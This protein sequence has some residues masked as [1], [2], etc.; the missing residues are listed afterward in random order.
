MRPSKFVK[1]S[2]G[3]V[4]E[5]LERFVRHQYERPFPVPS[6]RLTVPGLSEVDLILCYWNDTVRMLERPGGEQALR[7]H[8]D[9]ILKTNN[10]LQDEW[11]RCI[12]DKEFLEQVLEALWYEADE[13]GRDTLIP[14]DLADRRSL[15][16]GWTWKREGTNS[17]LLEVTE[18]DG[19]WI[20]VRDRQKWRRRIASGEMWSDVIHR[21]EHDM[22]E[23]NSK[24]ESISKRMDTYAFRLRIYEEVISCYDTYDC[25]FYLDCEEISESG[26][27]GH[28]LK[29]LNI[30]DAAIINTALRLYNEDGSI[31]TSQNKL[32]ETVSGTI[33]DYIDSGGK[34]HELLRCNKS[35]GGEWNPHNVRKVLNDLG[36]YVS[37]PG[38]GRGASSSP[39]VLLEEMVARLKQR[40]KE[41]EL[42]FDEGSQSLLI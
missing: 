28:E 30:I 18:P 24:F 1:P 17:F 29:S 39:G 35:E 31:Y 12:V 5:V 21:F 10:H 25:C 42:F 4:D 23:T 19:V 37:K 16:R 32:I 13:F 38:G 22:E 36:I 14:E 20:S 27:L 40:G 33:Q 8:Y 9:E 2:G 15:D 11:H 26:L 7:G 34:Y 6:A 3:V 41:S